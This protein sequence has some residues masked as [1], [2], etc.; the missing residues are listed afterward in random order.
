MPGPLSFNIFSNN[1]QKQATEQFI[2]QCYRHNIN[3]Y[4]EENGTKNIDK[5]FAYFIAAHYMEYDLGHDHIQAINQLA[6][7][8]KEQLSTEDQLIFTAPYS[9]ARFEDILQSTVNNTLIEA[10]LEDYKKFT[11]QGKSKSGA[12]YLAEDNF[13]FFVKSPQVS[14]QAPTCVQIN[15][16]AKRINAQEGLSST[17][18]VDTDF[19]Y[20]KIQR[21]VGAWVVKAEDVEKAI[22]AFLA[23]KDSDSKHRS[24]Y[25]KGGHY[26]PNLAL[27]GFLKK[28]ASLSNNALTNYGSFCEFAKEVKKRNIVDNNHLLLDPPCTFNVYDA[29]YRNMISRELM[30]SPALVNFSIFLVSASI[31]LYAYL[32]TRRA[33][34]A[35]PMLNARDIS[36]DTTPN[37]QIKIFA[38]YQYIIED[39]DRC[40]I[41]KGCPRSFWEEERSYDSN[42]DEWR[43][44]LLGDFDTTMTLY[45]DI[46]AGDCSVGTFFS[47]TDK[48]YEAFTPE[49]NE[50]KTQLLLTNDQECADDTCSNESTNSDHV[51]TP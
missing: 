49:F 40:V 22:T 1:H 44:Y 31:I 3:I 5:S 50:L 41:R 47:C 7:L 8:I 48:H 35:S 36:T 4:T 17:D 26:Q 11:E 43:S 33:L 28:N 16:L 12:R 15:A 34:E 6:A 21:I 2:E 38:N 37:D 24:K 46:D 30:I 32:F 20:G 25:F 51:A 27:L 18:R 23:W 19:S 29:A 13:I 39:L 9:L 42:F 10:L 45:R 14:K